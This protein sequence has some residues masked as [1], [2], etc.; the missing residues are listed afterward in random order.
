M[1]GRDPIRTGSL[2][3][4]QWEDQQNEATNPRCVK[5]N[6]SAKFKTRWKKKPQVQPSGRMNDYYY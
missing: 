2:K 3:S 4:D 1:Y 6:L 5:G